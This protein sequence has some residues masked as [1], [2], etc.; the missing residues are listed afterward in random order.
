MNL[1]SK[2]V[3]KL[4]IAI[5]LIINLFSYKIAMLVNELS[6][7]TYNF[8][9]VYPESGVLCTSISINFISLILCIIII[10]KMKS[11]DKK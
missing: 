7:L 5:I 3:G 2:L 6:L 4:S 8:Q 10:L 9:A 11:L 1:K